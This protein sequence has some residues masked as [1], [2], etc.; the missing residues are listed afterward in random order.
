MT[1]PQQQTRQTLTAWNRSRFILYAVFG[2]GFFAAAIAALA[3]RAG[4]MRSLTVFAVIAGALFAG[5]FVHRIMGLNAGVRFYYALCGAVGFLYLVASGSGEIALFVS[6]AM[7]P[8]LVVVLGYRHGAI[9]LGLLVIAAGVIMHWGFYLPG[10][11]SHF[12]APLVGAF[13]VVTAVLALFSLSLDYG[14]SVSERALAVVDSRMAAL[15]YRDPL[16]G[17][18]NRHAMET[19]LAKRWDEY[20]RSGHIFALLLCDIDGLKAINDRHGSA[21]GD[22]ALQKVAALLDRSLRSQDIVARWGDDEFLILLPGQTG[23]SALQ[24][25]ERLR[26]RVETMAL[27]AMEESVGVTI[28][29]GVGGVDTALDN[30]DLLSVAD[31]GLFQAKHMGRN[32]VIMG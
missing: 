27:S 24:A 4:D 8:G 23:N 26:K 30:T 16:T 6:L 9:L 3:F 17:L 15:A 11:Q 14:R 22:Q 20:R 28:S 18:T 7:V 13:L 1:N 32:Q 10:A 2:F 21:V 19:V 5:L 12:P 29:I 25:G 31:G